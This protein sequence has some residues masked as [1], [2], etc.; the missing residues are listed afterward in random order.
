MLGNNAAGWEGTADGEV[1][2]LQKDDFAS[3][4]ELMGLTA[5]P[6]AA[7]ISA[8]AEPVR[9]CLEFADCC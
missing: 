9:S 5:H 7:A 4:Q 6:D 1:V 8:A 2:S 3:A